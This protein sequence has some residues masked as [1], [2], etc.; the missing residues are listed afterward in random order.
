MGSITHQDGEL[1]VNGDTKINTDSAICSSF[2]F[3][4]QVN[5]PGGQCT[6]HQ[7]VGIEGLTEAPAGGDRS[8]EGN[9]GVVD[10]Y[11]P[12]GIATEQFVVKRKSR[13]GDTDQ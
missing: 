11:L 5:T 7:V 1:Q 9:Q 12:D 2:P 8:D 13:G 4:D 6:G 10:G 3:I